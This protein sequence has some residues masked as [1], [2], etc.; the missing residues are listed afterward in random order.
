LDSKSYVV[1]VVV[2]VVVVEKIVLCGIVGDTCLLT[3]ETHGRYCTGIAPNFIGK[4]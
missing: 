1:V 3:A 4:M 2:V